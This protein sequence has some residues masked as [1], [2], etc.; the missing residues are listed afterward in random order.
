MT[1]VKYH[2]SSYCHTV[3]IRG[4]I[5]GQVSFSSV[6]VIFSSVANGAAVSIT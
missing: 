4:G 6:G 5:Q 2:D 3:R 1:T